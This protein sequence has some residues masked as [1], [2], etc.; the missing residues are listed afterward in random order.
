MSVVHVPATYLEWVTVCPMVHDEETESKP[1][2]EYYEVGD[3][4]QKVSGNVVKHDTDPSWNSQVQVV[5]TSE[6]LNEFLRN[7]PPRGG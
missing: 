3:A 4:L 6:I 2:G 1:E 7:L 5:M